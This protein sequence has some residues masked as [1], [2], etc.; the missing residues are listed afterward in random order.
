LYVETPDGT[1]LFFGYKFDPVSGGRIEGD[2]NQLVFGMHVESV[3]FPETAPEGTYKFYVVPF[4]I[5]G[6]ADEWDLQ[7]VVEG[8][9]VDLYQG[10]GMSVT[11]EYERSL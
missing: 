2:T 11:F 5:R 6:E 10:T 3:F 8:M 9:E 4:N 7:V 1:I